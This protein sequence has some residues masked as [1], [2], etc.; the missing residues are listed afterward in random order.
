MVLCSEI[1]IHSEA[2]VALARHS[3]GETAMRLGFS[4]QR[5]A[6]MRLIASE[7]AQNHLDHNTSCGLLRISGQEIDRAPV[8]TICSLDNGPGI[9]NM[10]DVLQGSQ[11]G[12]RSLTGLG[13][14]LASVSRLADRFS[15][16]S[17]AD[18]DCGCP[19]GGDHPWP[20]TVITAR[21]WP[22]EQAPSF[23]TRDENTDIAALVCGRSETSPCGDGI[24]ISSDSR[25][26]RL[27]LVDSPGKGRGGG[28]TELIG[29]MLAEFNLIWPPDHVIES[30]AEVLGAEPATSICVLRFD[31]LLGKLRCCRTGTVGVHL[32]VD[33]MPA[34][35]PGQLSVEAGH[36]IRGVDSVYDVSAAASCLL[37]SDGL[38]GF[39]D[40]QIQ[41]LLTE[42]QTGGE[43]TV[44]NSR[45]DHALLA[46]ILFSRNRQSHDDAALCVWN[47]RKKC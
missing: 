22:R 42:L 17:G 7:L 14:G 11:G 23:C 47:W 13:T 27:V 21:C 28:E 6:E 19:T 4:D 46:Q 31:Q 36:M 25:F 38:A 45:P 16:C 1:S 39:A 43:T 9:C 10:T 3:A 32:Q 44:G 34:A 40:Q 37:Y 35:G 41:S 8:L 20:G 30:L 29:R 24:F 18:P 33:T 26:T 5:R 2:D 12:Y 15:C